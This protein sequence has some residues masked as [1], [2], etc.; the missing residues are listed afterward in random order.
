MIVR[1][2]LPQKSRS[3]IGP[4]CFAD[5]YG[6]QDVAVSGG[7]AGVLIAFGSPA[8]LALPAVLMYRTIAVWLP[9]PAGVASLPGMRATIARWGREDSGATATSPATA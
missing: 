9:L 6:P 7:M 1:R 4:W 8:G 5:H 2:T 3:L